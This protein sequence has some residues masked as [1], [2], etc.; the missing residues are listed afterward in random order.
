MDVSSAMEKMSVK[1]RAGVAVQ[2]HACKESCSGFQPHSWRKACIAC[3]CSTVDH[4]PGGDA[5]DDQQM[6]R[7]L[8]DS[9]CSHLTAKVKGGGGLRMYK[10]NR[11][12]VTNPVVS[13]KDPT[14]NT[15]TYDWA[16]AGLNQTLAMQYMELIP[17]SRRPLSGTVGALERRRQLFSQLPAYDQDPM[18]CQSLASEEEISSMLLFVKSYKQEVLGV[19]EVALPG[20]GGALREAAIQ[21]TAKEAKD[22]SNSDKKGA[23][24]QQHHGLTDSSTATVSGSTNG[25]DD[26]TKTVHLCTGCQ[27]EVAKESPAVYAERAGYHSALWHP[28]CFVCS[29]C[30]QGLV[31][32]VYFWSNKKLFCGRHY[33]QTVRPRCS[34]CDELI[35]CQSFHTA[36]DGQTWHPHHYCCWKCGQNLDTPCQH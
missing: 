1:Q 6:G 27:G 17:E 13:R 34:G 8:A 29:E 23:L 25:T 11:M 16:P 5:E 12:I 35:F 26:N 21:R 9:P 32:L 19:G 10:R 24:E 14:F 3:G 30:G 20:E 15:T 2:C 31:D 22:R 28:T 36:K 33:C 4:A 18:K 7:L